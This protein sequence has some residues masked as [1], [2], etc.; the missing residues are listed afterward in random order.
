MNKEGQRWLGTAL[1]VASAIAYS[2]AGFYTRLIQVDVW[3]VLF[4]RGDRKSVV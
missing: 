2:S 4:W 3:T 1:L